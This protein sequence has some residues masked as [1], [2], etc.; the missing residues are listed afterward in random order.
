[1]DP[2]IDKGGWEQGEPGSGG[3]ADPGAWEGGAQAPGH[4]VPPGHPGGWHFL[5]VTDIDTS[6]T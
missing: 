5:T 4:P 1:M 3:R 2:S 6:R